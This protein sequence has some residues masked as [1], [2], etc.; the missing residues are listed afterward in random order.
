MEYLPWD[1][2]THVKKTVLS[3]VY[4]SC[5]VESVEVVQPFDPKSGNR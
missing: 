4:I 1:I 5:D 2:T 3:S